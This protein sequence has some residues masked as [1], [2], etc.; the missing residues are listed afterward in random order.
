M[1]GSR[2]F[3]LR[4]GGTVAAG[5]VVAA[6]AGCASSSSSSAAAPATSSA[7]ASSPA[8]AAAAASSSAGSPGTSAAASPNAAGSTPPAAAGGGNGCAT[9]DL[10]ISAGQ[11]QG[12]AGSVY[13]T[14]DFTNTGS[15][16][17]TLYGY[18]GVSLATGSSATQV[19]AAAQRSATDSPKVVTLKPGAAANAV[20]RIT[21]AL[22]YPSASCSP[23]S[24]TVLR[25]YP[26]NETTAV[27]VAYKS[28][29]CAKESVKLL[30]IGAVQAGA[31]SRQ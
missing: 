28:M 16:S 15:A 10:K 11:A 5:A 21:Q 20:L 29:G 22:N 7:A 12:A 9:A 8:T 13:Q 31:T 25:V 14:I 26:P 3:F 18:P 30:T 27:T 1:M 23:Q 2:S 24:T 4:L 17:C 6:A 19:G